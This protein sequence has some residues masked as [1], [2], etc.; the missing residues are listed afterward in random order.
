MKIAI[1]AEGPEAI[2]TAER[3]KAEG[4][5][6]FIRNPHYFDSANFDKNVDVALAN[7][8]AILS[9]FKAVGVKTDTLTAVKAEIKATAPE[10]AKETA[11]KAEAKPA[12]AGR[13]KKK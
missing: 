7:D 13:P 10:I 12:K 8:P 2:K 5:Q 6:A 4:N 3:I 9:A 1:Y 11:I